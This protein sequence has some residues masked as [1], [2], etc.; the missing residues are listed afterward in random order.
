MTYPRLLPVLLF[1]AASL[2]GLKVLD[3]AAHRESWMA[4]IRSAAAEDA[5]SRAVQ[6]P[7]A[8][9]TPKLV[10]VPPPAP[11]APAEA[12]N[13]EQTVLERLGERRAQLE[14]RARELDMRENLL[15]AAEA[16]LE[17]RIAELKALETRA[18]EGERKRDEEA[19]ARIG[20]LVTMY[21]SM[22]AKDAA[23]ILGRLD[24]G[25]ALQVV[26][27]INP[28]K[29]ADIL[30]NMDSEAAQKLTVELALRGDKRRAGEM[31]T[32]QD[33]PKIETRP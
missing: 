30:A 11:A 4:P 25:V 27:R 33:L 5:H 26:E 13:A 15:K 10:E 18:S 2:L 21:E 12:P 20:A 29:M 28:R 24:T 7:A 3:L 16:R 9:R 19:K 6:T 23:R 17:A 32:E 22:R 8:G 31:R 14:A 1:A